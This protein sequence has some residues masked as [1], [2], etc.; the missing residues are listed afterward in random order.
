VIDHLAH[1]RADADA[2]LAALRVGSLSSVV[3]SCPGWTLR[4]LVLHLGGVHRWARQIVLTGEVQQQE[5]YEIDDVA[6]W[7]AEGADRLL[8][9]LAAADPAE[10][11]WSFTTDRTK[12]F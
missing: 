11:C 8:E 5:E 4:D 1:L 10:D 6:G 3:A 2:V 9:V 12:G 7:F